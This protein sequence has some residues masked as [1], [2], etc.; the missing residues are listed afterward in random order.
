MV[1]EILITN[2]R[3]MAAFK[4]LIDRD[5]GGANPLMKLTSHLTQDRALR[6][7]GLRRQ[8]DLPSYGHN[9]PFELA[10]EDQL[11]NEFLTEQYRFQNGP[12]TFRMDALLREMQEIEGTR[13]GLLRGPGVVD[14]ADN[15][16]EQYLEMTDNHQLPSTSD[17]QARDVNWTSE[18]LSSDMP[19]VSS[20]GELQWAKDYLE[21]NEHKLWAEEF[22]RDQAI[23][24]NVETKEG[25]HKEGHESLVD[26]W[27]DEF[28]STE[29]VEEDFWKNLEKEWGD[30]SSQNFGNYN[31][32][33]TDFDEFQTDSYYKE[34]KFEED[35]PLCDHPDPF[36]E[37]LKRLKMGDISNAVLLFEAAAQKDQTNAEVWQYL[38]TTQAANEQEPSAI[39][40]L[41][42]C[43]ELEPG[44]LTALMSLAVSYTNEVLQQKACDVLLQWLQKNPLYSH[45]VPKEMEEARDR[46]YY[47][48]SHNELKDLYIKAV[49][50]ETNEIDADVQI[51]LGVL[52]NLSGEFDK[53]VDCFTAALQIRPEDS[54]LWNKLGA[55][56]ANGRRS[57][58]AVS[59]YHRALDLSPG[60]VRTRYNLGIACINLG[61]Y[62]EAIEHF[63]TALNLQR[64]SLGPKGEQSVMSSNIWSSLRLAIS[65][66]GRTDLHTTC[67]NR[68]LDSFNKEFNISV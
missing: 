49:Q 3:Q 61:V 39:A 19:N 57:E 10:T 29:N 48:S 54:L 38:G 15:W 1:F 42:K 27:A 44:N 28:N 31:S 58:E 11:V 66:F 2:T 23:G 50:N 43:L 41:R 7:E 26:K 6:Q 32:W 12:T 68:D 59:A 67:D 5:C 35:N 51:G 9:V 40:A 45:L 22:S 4:E 53:A 14:L 30:S 55:T 34:Y 21:Q 65:L 37:G 62:R 17:A 25:L 16:T 56:L 36:S 24:P 18:Y 47:L 8:S 52:F 33:L 64:N 63:L 46:F 13:E 20:T 60:Y